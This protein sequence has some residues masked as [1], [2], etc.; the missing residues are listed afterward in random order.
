MPSRRTRPAPSTQARLHATQPVAP[1]AATI[2]VQLS[3]EEGRW[4]LT[5]LGVAQRVLEGLT[6]EEPAAHSYQIH[7]LAALHRIAERLPA[8]LQAYYPLSPRADQPA[9]TTRRTA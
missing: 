1:V 3:S 4:L 9:S 2:T 5:A 6:F 7:G 8:G